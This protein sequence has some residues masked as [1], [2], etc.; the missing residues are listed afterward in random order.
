MNQVT[1]NDLEA[2]TEK[3]TLTVALPR[4]MVKTVTINDD[5]TEYENV[6]KGWLRFGK[7]DLTPEQYN[8]IYSTVKQNMQNTLESQGLLDEAEKSTLN[9]MREIFQSIVD[10]LDDGYI[11]QIIWKTT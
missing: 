8:T 5:M 9:S 7:I 2:D 3:K 4:P 1:Q 11:V 6:Q 10:V